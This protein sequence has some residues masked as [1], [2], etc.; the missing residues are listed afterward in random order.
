MSGRQFAILETSKPA[1]SHESVQA[2]VYKHAPHPN[3][4]VQVTSLAS[5]HGKRFKYGA[6]IP[7]GK[8]ENLV[9]DSLLERAGITHFSQLHFD[10]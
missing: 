10:P 1:Y 4:V 9:S 7:S 2:P 5:Y 6:R 3:W 8:S